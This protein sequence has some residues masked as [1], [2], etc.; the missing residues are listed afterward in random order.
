MRANSCLSSR[1]LWRHK[2][3]KHS[4]TLFVG[5]SDA[6]S[7]SLYEHVSSCKTIATRQTRLYLDNSSYIFQI[8]ATST[9]SPAVEANCPADIVKHLVSWPA[10]ISTPKFSIISLLDSYKTRRMSTVRCQG[11]R[12]LGAQL[13]ARGPP[14]SSFSPTAP[15]W[16]GTSSQQTAS[17]GRPTSR[18]MAQRV[19]SASE[20]PAE[21]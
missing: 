6:F 19:G 16:K 9:A 12:S 20:A 7:L 1:D 13:K 21:K 18:I 2:I 8:L 15:L 10:T 3:M 5:L 17:E 4:T 14:V 11:V